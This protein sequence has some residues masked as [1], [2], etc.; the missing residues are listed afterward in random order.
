MSSLLK[1]DRPQPYQHLKSSRQQEGPMPLMEFLLREH[2]LSGIQ[3]L[4]DSPCHECKLQM[5]STASMIHRSNA[6]TQDHH[7]HRMLVQ[8]TDSHRLRIS[9]ISPDPTRRGD[10]CHHPVETILWPLNHQPSRTHSNPFRTSLS[11]QHLQMHN[12]RVL[13]RRHKELPLRR[14]TVHHQTI[15][16]LSDS[17]LRGR[18]K[19][20]NMLMATHR[21]PIFPVSTPS[22][23]PLYPK[24]NEHPELTPGAVRPSRENKLEHLQPR[25]Q[26]LS[27]LH[28]VQRALVRVAR[29]TLSTRIKTSIGE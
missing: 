20:C 16:H 6:P 11:A 28:P 3:A 13:Y 12:K 24:R 1:Q 15:D 26:Q 19:D 9:K 2:H 8:Y 22:L 25:L 7:V 10:V 21:S 23:S 29:P 27:L 17:L 14:R 18:P 4:L 5:G